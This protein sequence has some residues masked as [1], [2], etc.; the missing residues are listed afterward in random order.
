MDAMRDSGSLGVC[1]FF[2]RLLIWATRNCPRDCDTVMTAAT[3]VKSRQSDSPLVPAK[4][5]GQL[6]PE[7]RRRPVRIA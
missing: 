2:V 5:P 7:D 1:G 3:D 4:T 6:R